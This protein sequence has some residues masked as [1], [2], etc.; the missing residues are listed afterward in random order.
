MAA[1]DLVIQGT[2]R[3][4]PEALSLINKRIYEWIHT[5][6]QLR[7]CWC[8]KENPR[9]CELQ[10]SVVAWRRVEERRRKKHDF[11][12]CMEVRHR[13]GRDALGKG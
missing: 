13:A 7:I 12:S 8:L 5:E 4:S 1:A 10:A 9:A 2:P 11:L 6:A 3:P